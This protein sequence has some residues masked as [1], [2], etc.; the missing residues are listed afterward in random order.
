MEL[1]GIRTLDNIN[2]TDRAVF[3]R[4]DFNVPMD[5]DTI[6]DDTRIR[7]TLPTLQ[8]LRD[9]GARLVLGSH[10]G[11]PRGEFRE[12][13]S[14]INVAGHLSG[15]V[16][17]E[18]LFAEEPLG[19]GV[20]RAIRDL[21]MGG[22]CLLENLRFRPEEQA[23]DPAYSLALAR[24]ADVYVNDAFGTAHRAH[25]STYGMVQHFTEN[26]RAAGLLVARELSFLAPLASRP[27]RPFVAVLGGAK[28][29]DKIGVIDALLGK[30]DMLMVG[31]AMAYTF[32]KAKG[33]SVGD[34]L[35][36]SEHVA[37][38][39]RL[40]RSAESRKTRVVLPIDHIVAPSIDSSVGQETETATI[41][42]GWAAFDIGPQTR[43]LYQKLLRKTET[44]FWNGPMG[45]F[46]R[47]PFAEGTRAVAQAIVDSGALSVIGG[48]DS[49]AA[50]KSFGLADR[51]S[52]VST[53]GGASLEFLEGR[54]L[55]GISALRAGHRFA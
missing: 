3:V 36:E 34:S 6:T 43:D 41:S 40:L 22:V 19:E 44:V 13:L 27:E 33:V 51:F 2:V 42:D 18:V 26:R 5:G 35:V 8:L 55:P 49:A 37:T 4:V 48:G 12:D 15:L 32:L 11:R 38:A 17:A 23:C 14:L 30:I 31:G 53:G 1:S 16:D 25:A 7:A 39:A 54:D 28:V 50:A 9:A 47:E 10:L 46:E 21:P 20:G 45:V 24:L 52:H 29:S